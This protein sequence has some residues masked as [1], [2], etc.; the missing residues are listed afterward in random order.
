MKTSLPIRPNRR[1]FLKTGAAAAAGV[2]FMPELLR[3]RSR[4]ADLMRRPFGAIDFETTTFGLGGQASLQW[5]PSDVDPVRIILKAFDEGVNYFDTSNL[6]GP[7]QLNYGEAF[8]KLHLRP[9]VAGY[10]ESY[11]RSVFIT[12]KTHL[13]WGKGHPEREGVNNWSNGDPGGNTADDIRRSLSQMFGDGKGHYPAGAYLDMML[14]HNL[15]TPQEVEAL[16]TGL[17]NPDPGQEE[18]GALAVLRDFRDGSNLTGQNPREERLIRHIG[19]SGHFSAPVMM[20]MIRRDTSRILDAM[21]VAINA[22][23]RLNLNMQ[24]NVIPVAAARNMGIIAMKVFADG[25]MYTK[26][27]RWSR[28]PDD[29]VRTV[30]SRQLPSRP[31]IGYALTTPGISTAIVGI[32][33]ISSERSACQLKQN[34]AASQIGPDGFSQAD[35]EEVELLAAGVRE[36]KTNYF[37]EP[38]GNL[39]PPNNFRAQ[40]VTESG[41]PAVRITW[42]SAYAGREPLRH[43]EVWSQGTLLANVQHQPQTDKNPFEYIDRSAPGLNKEFILAS[44]DNSGQKAE[45]RLTVGN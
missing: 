13:R 43:Y 40:R 29:V 32:G 5:T 6:Y 17:D 30:G 35:R 45:V 23:D 4:S 8:Q 28:T 15:N 25:A 16:Y 27:P 18:I 38:V 20:E 12:S 1:E 37:Q 7:S 31:L 14:I 9:G 21:L 42:D 39:S 33:Q 44:V 19:F 11:R 34:I 36:G 22:N 41:K 2:M 26:E 3:A 10:D 24:H